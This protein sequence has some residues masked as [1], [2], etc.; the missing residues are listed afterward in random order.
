ME[1]T[2]N[3]YISLVGNTKVRDRLGDLGVDRK[4]LLKEVL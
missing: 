1:E 4:V 3:A 2:L